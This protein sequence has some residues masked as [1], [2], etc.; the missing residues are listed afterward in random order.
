G[1]SAKAGVNEF[2][3]KGGWLGFSDK[4]WLS[5]IIPDQNANMNAGFRKDGAQ[6][7]AG[8]VNT[9]PA[10]NST[11]RLYVGTKDVDLLDH[12]QNQ[13]G[14]VQFSKA[15]DW[16]WFG[17]IAK[18]MFWLIHWLYGL[19]GNFGIAIILTTMIVRLFT[20]PIFDRQFSSMARMKAVQPKMKALQERF[21]DDKMQL[22]QETMKLYRDEKINPLAGCLP[23]LLQIPILF[24]LFKA[25]SISLDMRHTTFL[26]IHDLSA[27]DPMLF[28]LIPGVE[29]ILPAFLAIGMLPLAN[30]VIMWAQMKLNPI[31][32]TDPTQAQMMKFMPW[33]MMFF[34]SSVAAGLA[35]YYVVSGLITILQQRIL[36]ARHP[37]MRGPVGPIEA[38]T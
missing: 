28:G 7:R 30:G 37:G 14:I 17:F 19:V 35:L 38:I 12:Y 23:V 22:Q 13:G 9:A 1:T 29:A 11:T 21:K 25:F 24:S 32:T 4:Y 33:M 20:F 6:Y 10:T 2:V 26:W 5:A 31:P 15:I 34:F 8:F 36:Y 27:R 18:P 3:S 16:G